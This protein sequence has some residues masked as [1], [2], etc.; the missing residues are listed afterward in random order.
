LKGLVAVL[1]VAAGVALAAPAFAA[2]EEIQVYMDEMSKPGQFGL[3]LHNNYVLSGDG[4]LDYAGQMSSLHRYR[5]T[6]EWSYGLTRDVELGLYLP[7]TTLDGEGHF[8]ADGIKGRVKWIA[9]HPE[10]QTWFWGANLEIGRVAHSLDENPWN[11]E[12]KGIVG[13]RFGR[14]TVASNL[15]FDFKV[16]GPAPAPAS[17]DFDTKV[18]YAVTKDFAIGVESYNGLGTFKR[19]GHFGEAD[20]TLYG[21]IDAGLGKWDLNLGL[22]HGY[23]SSRDGWV[24]KAIIGVPIDG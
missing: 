13:G 12:L 18:S 17:L 8:A 1:T 2:D 23:G 19:F 4:G 16:S 14:W 9:P 22:G 5:L 10:S 21:V 11:G 3:D 6:P 7:L 15:N 24:L 20:Q